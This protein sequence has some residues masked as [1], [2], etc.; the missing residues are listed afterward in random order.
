M[1]LDVLAL[2]TDPETAMPASFLAGDGKGPDSSFLIGSINTPIFKV[3]RLRLLKLFGSEE[4][5]NAFLSDPQ[6][7]ARALR[8][9]LWSLGEPR[10]ARLSRR[11]AATP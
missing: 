9:Y 5:L 8:D 6:Q 2:G 4:E 11:G 3:D 10:G 1:P 7:V